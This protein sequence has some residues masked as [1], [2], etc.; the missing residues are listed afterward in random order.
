MT[1]HEPAK[2]RRSARP[3]NPVQIA[4]APAAIA[5]N[6]TQANG[7][8][9]HGF[10]E[11][12]PHDLRLERDDDEQ[13][14]RCGPEPA[15]PAI[16][17][18][19]HQPC[20]FEPQVCP[21]VRRKECRREHGD[22]KRVPVE[23]PDPAT[24]AEVGEE[25]HAEVSRSVQRHAA[26][27]VAERRAKQ[28]RQEHARH[29]E[30]EIPGGLP[31]CVGD[32]AADFNRNAAQDKRPQH[33]PQCQVE[34]RE[35][36]RHDSGERQ[37]EGSACCH[38]PHFIPAPRRPDRGDH[39]S[40]LAIV[41]GDE[42]LQHARADVPAVEDDEH[43]ERQAQERKPQ[44]SHAPPPP[45]EPRTRRTAKQTARRRGRG[46]SRGRPGTGTG[47]R[48]RSRGRSARSA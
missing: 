29:G 10:I 25:R 7:R 34:P 11:V 33:Q 6:E 21:A 30:H 20:R 35:R 9:D 16:A 17:P 18:L 5:A 37:H 15:S 43:G 26:E 28:D 36:Y 41:L 31:Q 44:F 38:E 27:H 39:L 1:A 45:E 22:G 24:D 4:R 8:S 40:A 32:V 48:A 19:V 42:Q 3:R 13:H 47:G 14:G 46:R 12:G 23:N 2:A